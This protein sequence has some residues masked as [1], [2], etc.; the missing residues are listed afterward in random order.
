MTNI[1]AAP[2]RKPNSATEHNENTAVPQHVN[3]MPANPADILARNAQNGGEKKRV[4]GIVW[5]GGGLLAAQ[6][7]APQPMKPTVVAGSAVAG[8]YSQ[9][10]AASSDKEED[11]ARKRVLAERLADLEARWSEARAKCFWTGLAGKEAAEFC[12]LAVDQNFIPAINQV[13]RQ[14]SRS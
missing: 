9:I 2:L 12:T 5:M 8:F 14:L 11:L 1:I 7:L 13:R 3:T 6:I 4:R 10:M